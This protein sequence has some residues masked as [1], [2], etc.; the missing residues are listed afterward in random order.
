VIRRTSLNLDLD[1]VEQ[2][3]EVLGTKTT[4]ETV[5]T[6]LREAVRSELLKRLAQRR[7][8]HMPPGWLEELRRGE[9]A[10]ES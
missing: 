5:H 9:H 2:A 3:R 8:D 10:D 7:F 4:T 1:L 6:A